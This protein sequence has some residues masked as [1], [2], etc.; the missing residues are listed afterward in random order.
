MQSGTVDGPALCR[1]FNQ[2]I[3]GMPTLPQHISSD[4]DPLFQFHR[5][6][7]NLRILDVSE[8]KTVP[9]VSI[10]HPFV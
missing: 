6:K 7:A 2:V 8:I 5:W 1:M 9:H 10:S 4:H 3:A